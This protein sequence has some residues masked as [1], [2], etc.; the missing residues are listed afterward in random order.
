MSA[1]VKAS[2]PGAA[3]GMPSLDAHAIRPLRPDDFEDVRPALEA[4]P[5]GI[6]GV[7]RVEAGFRHFVARISQLPWTLPFACLET[8]RATGVCFLNV[9][10]PRHLSAYLVALFPEP[11]GATLAL[12]LYIRHVFWSLPLHRLYTHVPS[13]PEGRPHA[14]L[15]TRVGF[16][17]EGSL[18]AHIENEGGRA[19]AMVLGLLRDDFTAWCLEHEPR[20]RLS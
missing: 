12:A 20:L 2:T 19:D 1:P 5:P 17:H 11:A 10:E 15:L 6:F 9:P 14:D 4:V 8:G 7:P 18:L 13:G 16:V 3:P